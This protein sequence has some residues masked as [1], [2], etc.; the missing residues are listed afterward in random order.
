MR[1]NWRGGGQSLL[2]N[3]TID[4]YVYLICSKYAIP[5]PGLHCAG[6]LALC[7]FLQYLPAKYK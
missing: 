1:K 7:G 2:K 6:L 3:G 4:G 5:G